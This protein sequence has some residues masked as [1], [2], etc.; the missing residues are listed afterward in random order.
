M[1]KAERRMSIGIL[2][3]LALVA[4]LYFYQSFAASRE[5]EVYGVSVILCA[6]GDNFQKGFNGAALEDNADVHV[7]SVSDPDSAAQTTALE[8]ELK[9]GADAVILYRADANNLGAWLAKNNVSAPLVLVGEETPSG[10]GASCVT[11]DVAAQAQALAAEMG[12]QPLRSVILVDGGGGSAPRLAALRKALENA[13]FS[14]ELVS[15]GDMDR[16]RPGCVYVALDPSVALSL[17]ELRGEGALVYCMGYDAALRGALE[18]GRIAALAS[19]SEFD[20]GYF[21]MTEAVARIG[22][23]RAAE[24]KLAPFIACSDNMYEPP[25]STILFPIG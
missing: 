6:E 4:A 15:A 1:G 10:K 12:K 22:G 14:W 7:V 17:M 11:L 13:G 3:L 2:A 18:S 20:A 24:V 9:N 8:R 16:L 21:A 19:A 23:Q 5:A 25:I